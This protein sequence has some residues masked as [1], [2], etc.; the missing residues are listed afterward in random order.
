MSDASSSDAEN[1]PPDRNLERV[2]G[3]LAQAR[4]EQRLSA[5]SLKAADADL[6]RLLALSGG[7]PFEA[8]TPNHIRRFVGQLNSGGLAPSSI[9]RVLSS[10]RSFFAQE[11]R[12]KRL[13][14]N[15]ALGVRA[16]KRSKTLPKNLDADRASALFD[17]SATD[18][19]RTLR[20]VAMLELLYGSGLR[21]AEL[22]GCNIGDVDLA[23]GSVRVTGKG[24]KQRQVPLGR[25]SV[26]ALRRW[27]ACRVDVHA[28]APLFTGRP[29]Q[30]IS[31]RTVQ[32]ILK[33]VSAERLGTNE[34]HPHMLRHSFAS[35]LLA[36]KVRDR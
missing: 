29:G 15:P 31:P 5:N 36:R 8:L 24:S 18:D 10:W 22:V 9:A 32:T 6:Q 13:G 21:L 34:L 16:P 20:N 4:I 27:L 17:E 1:P 28:D 11:V 12:S 25:A 35:H 2:A 23:S 30:R 33:R 14:A 26:A 3:Y 7:S 19:P